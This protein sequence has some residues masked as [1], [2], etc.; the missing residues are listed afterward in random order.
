MSQSPSNKCP[1]VHQD[2]SLNT[3]LTYVPSSS[4]VL[5]SQHRGR[6]SSAS[7]VSAAIGLMHSTAIVRRH[8]TRCIRITRF[9]DRCVVN[10]SAWRTH[11]VLILYDV[12]VTVLLLVMREQHCCCFCSSCC[13][14][15][16]SKVAHRFLC[17]CE[18]WVDYQSP[19]PRVYSNHTSCTEV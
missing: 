1:G 13:Y 2:I 9:E 14:W 5:N 7:A 11:D 6:L 10:R 18:L 16:R 12:I 17:H 4:S 3:L 19:F 8:S 15:V